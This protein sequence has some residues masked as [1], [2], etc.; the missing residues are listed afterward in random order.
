MIISFCGDN[1]FYGTAKLEEKLFTFLEKVIDGER[2]CFYL[3]G[4]GTFDTFAYNVYKKYKEKHSNVR[5]CYVTPSLRDR[6]VKRLF[7]H[8]PKN[9]IWSYIPKSRANLFVLR[10]YTATDG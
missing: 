8:R 10:F 6:I 7:L 2:V 3:K 9:T 5:L 4:S 1:N